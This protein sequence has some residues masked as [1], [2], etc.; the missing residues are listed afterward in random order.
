MFL[1]IKLPSFLSM[2]Q[3]Y[4]TTHL[5]LMSIMI[6]RLCSMKIITLL[7]TIQSHQLSMS[8]HLY[9][10][11]TK[12][13]IAHPLSMIMLLL[14]LSLHPFMMMVTMIIIQYILNNH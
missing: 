8:F 13:Y 12:L 6:I 4:M 9:R 14:T 3:I 10:L 5:L 2:F 11:I 1:G 7:F